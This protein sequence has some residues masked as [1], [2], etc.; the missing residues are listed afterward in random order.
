MTELGFNPYDLRRKCDRSKDGDLC[1]EQMKWIETYLNDPRNKAALGVN[2]DLTFTS[3]NMDLNRD[4]MFQG[5]GMRN[6]A[7]LLPELVN[8]GIR[9]LVYAGNAGM[10]AAPSQFRYYLNVLPFNRFGV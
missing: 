5:D 8:D 9:L 3:C 6:S 4:F 2:P 7:L 1:Y 10:F